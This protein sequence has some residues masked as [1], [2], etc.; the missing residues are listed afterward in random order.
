MDAS[1]GSWDIGA[2]PRAPAARLTNKTAALR[3]RYCNRSGDFPEILSYS[4]KLW[5]LKW[6][7]WME[8]IS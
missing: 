6:R 3:A 4:G 1:D 7:A 5:L 2:V 8:I